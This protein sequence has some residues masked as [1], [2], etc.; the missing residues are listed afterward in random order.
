MHALVVFSY[1]MSS[2]CKRS[3]PLFHSSADRRR[4]QICTVLPW[5]SWGDRSARPPPLWPRCPSPSSSCVR[6]MA[7]SKRSTKAWPPARSRYR[8]HGY[9]RT[10]LPHLFT[11]GDAIQDTLSWTVICCS[12]DY[13]SLHKTLQFLIEGNSISAG[14]WNKIFLSCDDS[15]AHKPAYMS[16]N[17]LYCFQTEN[18]KYHNVVIVEPFFHVFPSADTEI[19]TH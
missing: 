11:Q 14:L 16:Q 13:C 4:T 3:P 12:V 2:S 19:Q 18:A 6:A 7:S 17:I 5:R 8:L 10:V 15:L 9:R 1:S